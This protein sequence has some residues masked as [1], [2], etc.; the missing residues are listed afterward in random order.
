ML[1]QF[2]R[3][4]GACV[5]SECGR[6]VESGDCARTFAVC[7]DGGLGDHTER[8]LAELGITQDRYKE[9]KRRFG[10]A[11]ACDCDKRKAWLNRVGAWFVTPTRT[12]E[13]QD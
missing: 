3:R 9:A 2:E 5:C 1:C 6:R 8:L 11:P 7:G 12:R 13:Q 4:E 10:L